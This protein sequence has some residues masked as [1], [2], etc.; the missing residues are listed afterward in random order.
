SFHQLERSRF[1]G[2]GLYIDCQEYDCDIQFLGVMNFID[3]SASRGGGLV[4]TSFASN[5][6]IMSNQCIFLNCSSFDGDGGG[7]YL[8][9]SRHPFQVQITGN[10][11]FED[12][13]CSA[14]GGGMYMSISSG[15]SVTLDNKC[16]FLKCK[17]GNGGAMY[18]RINF[19]QQSS[20]QIKDI[21]IQECQALINTESTIYSQSGFGGGIFIAGT[22]VYDI[23]SKMLD[24]SKM[25]MYGNSADKAGQSLYVAMPIVIEWCRT[26][27]NGEYV[28]G[29]YSDIDSDE[30]DLE[31]IRVGYSNFNDLSQVDIVKDQRPLELW[32]RTIWHILNRNE[33][34]FKG[35]DQIGCSEYNNPCYSIDYAIEQIS[36]ELGGILTSTIAEKRIGICEEGY[37]LTSPIQF[38]KSSTYTNIIKIMK[39]LYM[40]KYNM[41]GKAEI[42]II[43]GG[44]ASN[45]ENGHKGWISAS[46]GIELKFY[47]IKLVTDK[48][49][50]NIPIIYI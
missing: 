46:G 5:Q 48:S 11:F 45:I 42:K 50:F 29:N 43:K 26:G 20:I 18:L 47:F 13:S 9:F 6:I 35:I 49:K 33:K 36:V 23:S 4:I 17:S 15:G 25:K 10:I 27:I 16:E 38:S 30:S 32:W 24:F 44:Y 40:T 7:I 3:C 37:D 34:A 21:L 41:E 8:Y 28:K 22:G 1:A 14:S 2:G 19:E 12:C 31:G 39:Q